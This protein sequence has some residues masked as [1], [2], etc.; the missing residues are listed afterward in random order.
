M[1]NTVFMQN[2]KLV[3]YDDMLVKLTTEQP[4]PPPFNPYIIGGRL[5]KSAVIGN[6]EWLAENLDFKWDGL[7]VGAAAHDPTRQQANYYDQDEDTYGN[8]YGLLYN[9]KAMEYLQEN[10][11][12]LIPG[13]RIPTS[14]EWL[15][16]LA[17]A[18][19]GSGQSNVGRS[20]LRSTDAGWPIQADG[21]AT[22]TTG[23]SAVPSGRWYS[24]G[25]YEK[26]GSSFHMLT[27]SKTES[28][29]PESQLYIIPY[30]TPSFAS[31]E[32]AHPLSDGAE[33]SI[34]LIRDV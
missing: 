11:A 3:Q 21:P 26:A 22:N 25:G 28:A 29:H 9:F 30:L 16:L 7:E 5:Y 6:Q 2:G 17:F 23:F 27:C 34:R 31:S 33:G 4:S 15:E 8:K 20:S 24:L 19:G 18:S 10:R 14:D 32:N 1:F 12:K 13:W